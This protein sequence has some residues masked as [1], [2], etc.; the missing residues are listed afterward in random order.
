M[1]LLIGITPLPNNISTV[2]TSEL[3]LGVIAHVFEPMFIALSSGLNTEVVS[4]SED[5]LIGLARGG[6]GRSYIEELADE[7]YP[8]AT[9]LASRS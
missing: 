8:D 1:S 2:P 9:T 4:L 7:S 6:L 3:D 5:L